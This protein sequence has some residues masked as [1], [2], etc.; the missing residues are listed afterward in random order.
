MEI[1][2]KSA[3][4]GVRSTGAVGTHTEDRLT[5]VSRRCCVCGNPAEKRCS[6]CKIDWYCGRKCQVAAWKKH[7][8]LCD[9]LCE[10]AN[11]QN[12]GAGGVSVEGKVSDETSGKKSGSPGGA[13]SKIQVMDD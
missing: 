5:L 11:L 13:T 6:R 9:T 4:R 2:L 7:K 12:S 10:A 1:K 8:P 3:A